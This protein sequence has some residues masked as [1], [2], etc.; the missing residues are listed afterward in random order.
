MPVVN[1]KNRPDLF[2]KRHNYK[3]LL[4]GFLLPQISALKTK[5][6]GPIGLI[7]LTRFDAHLNVFLGDQ[8][9]NL[10]QRLCDLLT[11]VRN[12]QSR[13]PRPKNRKQ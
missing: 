12:H 1:N 4:K 7:A 3:R 6:P 11:F 10:E 2:I 13:S 5:P 8:M 9:P